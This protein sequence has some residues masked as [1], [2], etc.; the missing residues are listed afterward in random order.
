MRSGRRSSLPPSAS[1]GELLFAYDTKELFCGNTNNQVV[2]VRDVI[3]GAHQ[4]STN[5]R[6][7]NMLWLNTNNNRLMRWNGSDFVYAMYQDVRL[8]EILDDT[9]IATDKMW[10]SQKISDELDTKSDVGHLHTVSD[11]TNFLHHTQPMILS[12]KDLPNSIA[13]LTGGL[14]PMHHLPKEIK[15][16]IV[17]SNLEQRDA[18][19]NLYDSLMVFVEDASADPTVG[20][21]DV[22]PPDTHHTFFGFNSTTREITSYSV[23]GPKNVV[24]PSH[25]N[26]VEV[27]SIKSMA[28]RDIVSVDIP[29]TVTSIQSLAFTDNKLSKVIIPDTVL[30]I[31]TGAFGLNPIRSIFLRGGYDFG[32]CI[33]DLQSAFKNAYEAKGK[34][35]G[36]Y[37]VG[38]GGTPITGPWLYKEHPYSAL[39]IRSGS[40]WLKV[41]EKESLDVVPWWDKIQNIP[42]AVQDTT[43]PF[44]VPWVDTINNKTYKLTEEEMDEVHNAHNK[45]AYVSGDNTS[46]RLGLG[47]HDSEYNFVSLDDVREWNKVAAGVNHI[48]ATRGDGTLWSWGINYAG[49]LGVGDTNNRTTPTQI[50]V[51]TDWVDVA[52][53]TETSFAIKSDGTLYAWGRNTDGR[54]GVGDLENKLVPTYVFSEEGETWRKISGGFN[55]TIGLK[56]DGTVWS[57]GANDHG[58]LGLGTANSTRIIY[59]RK[60]IL[61]PGQCKDIAAGRFHVLTVDSLG[62]LRVW[63]SNTKGELGL[64]DTTPHNSPTQV[65]FPEEMIYV[66]AGDHFSI[67]HTVSTPESPGTLW[68]WGDNSKGQLGLDSTQDMH[69]T[70]QKIVQSMYFRDESYFRVSAIRDSILAIREDRKVFCWGNFVVG[71][72]DPAQQNKPRECPGIV[73][74][75]EVARAFVH[76]IVLSKADSL[77]SNL[78]EVVPTGDPQGRGKYKI[79]PHRWSQLQTIN[80]GKFVT[81]QGHGGT[82]VQD[83][84]LEFGQYIGTFDFGSIYV[85]GVAVNYPAIPRLGGDQLVSQLMDGT[86]AADYN[87]FDIG[88]TS[89]DPAKQMRWI[90]FRKRANPLAG[91]IGRHPDRRDVHDLCGKSYEYIFLCD[92]TIK[93]RLTNPSTMRFRGIWILSGKTV[94]I[95]GVDYICRPMTGRRDTPITLRS[96]YFD[97]MV[98]AYQTLGIPIHI[99]GTP[100]VGNHYGTGFFTID[101]SVWNEPTRMTH[102]VGYDSLTDQ[103]GLWDHDIVNKGEMG[104]RPCL[105]PVQHPFE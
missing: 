54:L 86:V 46:G 84:S 41:S 60:I 50:G 6:T 72:G 52:C 55:F 71:T 90:K 83:D 68:L 49:E 17:V 89:A 103:R 31:D 18:L 13:G 87:N 27:N 80:G 37:Y 92:R 95:D 38:E 8:D 32:N 82:T 19:T 85:D 98:P 23:N 9:E 88:D 4:P 3:I 1:P 48:I 94:T 105:V 59:P 28:F 75:Y 56:N 65:S 79:T 12:W 40:E 96:E 11:I 36:L 26:G 91:G 25:I 10:S 53:G 93:T 29:N 57:W 39:Y 76:G 21:S 99:R 101:S 43:V 62:I 42:T 47:H 2:R 77:D 74:A 81:H 33:I 64:G 35:K 61:Y 63:G 97:L 66:E 45:T 51:D 78:I 67:A 22:R 14:I 69:T 34:K 20:P 58:Q 73:D 15:E 104:F 70:P 16:T 7:L 24:I 102:F 5:Q 30:S 100:S 44:T